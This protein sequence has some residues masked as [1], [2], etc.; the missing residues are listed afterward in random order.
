MIDDFSFA[1][2]HNYA[3]HIHISGAPTAAGAFRIDWETF[4]EGNPDWSVVN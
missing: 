1:N 3:Y 2:P 4:Y